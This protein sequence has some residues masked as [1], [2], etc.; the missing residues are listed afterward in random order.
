M[1]GKRHVA[2]K[3]KGRLAS[4]RET[5]TKR[6]FYKS[7]GEKGKRRSGREKSGHYGKIRAGGKKMVGDRLPRRQDAD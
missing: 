6:L 5:A 2:M 3:K 7:N 1:G 4:G